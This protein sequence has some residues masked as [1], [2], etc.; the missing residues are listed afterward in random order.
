MICN[1][2]LIDEPLECL[3]GFRAF[4]NGNF[5]VVLTGEYATIEWKQFV[6]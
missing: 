6:C 2:R 3:F 5:V 4:S 1:T